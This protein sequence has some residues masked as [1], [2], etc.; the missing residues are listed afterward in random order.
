[1]VESPIEV[2]AVVTN[3]DKPAGRGME[4][5]P[6]PVKEEAL[7]HGLEVLQPRRAR[8][9]ELHEQLT[10]LAPDVA[11]VVAYGSILPG[12][13]LEVPK[14]GFVNLHF[15]LL[16]AYRGAAP[17]QRAVMDGVAVSGVSIM[18]LTEGMDEGPVLTKQEV[19]VEP[20]DTAGALGERMADLGAPLLVETITRYAA[21]DLQPVEQDHDEATYAPKI[22]TEE[23]RID[24]TKPA[25]EIAYLVR[26]LNPAP[27][28]WTEWDGKRLKVWEVRPVDERLEPGAVV[29]MHGALLAGT[30]TEAVELAD[31]QL[32]GK[33]RMGGGELARGLRLT[34]EARLS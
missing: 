24:W 32:A 1:M 30:G 11:V 16:P 10:A 7:R 9:P 5:R 34:P 3:P 22:T 26:G 21:G 31:V 17:V 28:A 12:P 20:S 6:S 19:P 4:L 8:E 23:A 29:E 13:L 33:R 2:A 14:L 27:G 18:V 25:Q 15:S